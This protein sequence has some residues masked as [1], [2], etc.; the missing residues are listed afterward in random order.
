MNL[1]QLH[2]ERCS[3]PVCMIGCA[4]REYLELPSPA[5]PDEAAVMFDLAT[6][7]PQRG[8]LAIEFEEVLAA[9]REARAKLQQD[10]DY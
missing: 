1:E 6:Q 5:A 8:G 2:L 10:T 7:C 3:A 4:L 9:S